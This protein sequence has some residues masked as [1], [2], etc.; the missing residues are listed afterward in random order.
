MATERD[1]T[2]GCCQWLHQ[3]PP[4]RSTRSTA[5]HRPQRRQTGSIFLSEMAGWLVLDDDIR[6]HSHDRVH[7]AEQ[8]ASL[9]PKARN[10]LSTEPCEETGKASLACSLSCVRETRRTYIQTD[11]THADT[12]DDS[13]PA[14][15]YR[16][17]SL[18]CLCIYTY[19]AYSTRTSCRRHNVRSFPL[20]PSP[21][22]IAP[23]ALHI[24]RHTR[25]ILATY[26]HRPSPGADCHFT[27]PDRYFPC[28]KAEHSRGTLRPSGGRLS[29]SV[30]PPRHLAA[31]PSFLSHA[32]S[33]RV[34]STGG[35]ASPL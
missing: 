15:T 27:V 19:C 18:T 2:A 16:P 25:Y 7:C 17:A 35:T 29:N 6:T 24:A 22:R 14:S 30:R 34:A 8:T 10:L 13:P 31:S 21:H 20:S 26:I 9:A 12:A 32:A 5:P 11:S 3:A 1:D 23:S 33:H 28:R 4:Q